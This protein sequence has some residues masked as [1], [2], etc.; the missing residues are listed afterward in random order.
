MQAWALTLMF[1]PLIGNGLS[2]SEIVLANA[3]LLVWRFSTG[4]EG[5]LIKL[6]RHLIPVPTEYFGSSMEFAECVPFQ[7]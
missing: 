3:A 4:I 1:C 6:P 5:E 7:H 2:L